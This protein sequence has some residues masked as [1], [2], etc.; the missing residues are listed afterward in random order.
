MGSGSSNINVLIVAFCESVQYV[1]LNGPLRSEWKPR[2][3]REVVTLYTKRDDESA[4]SPSPWEV[5]ANDVRTIVV[6]YGK[7]MPTCNSERYER[8]KRSSANGALREGCLRK[9]HLGTRERNGRRH[10]KGV[11]LDIQ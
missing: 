2:L 1:R 6:Q 7:R 4:F 10:H 11:C 3:Q 9:A 8:G 5:A